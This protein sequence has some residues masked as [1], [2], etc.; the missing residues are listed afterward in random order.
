MQLLS[1]LHLRVAFCVWLCV[2]STS[3]DRPRRVRPLPNP[4]QPKNASAS[5]HYIRRRESWNLRSVSPPKV[6]TT[7]SAA[8]SNGSATAGGFGDSGGDAS[9]TT[10]GVSPPR[11]RET[12]SHRAIVSDGTNSTP[13]ASPRQTMLSDLFQKSRIAAGAQMRT[14]TPARRRSQTRTRT[15]GDGY[16]A[17]WRVCVCV[18]FVL[19]HD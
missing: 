18:C 1:L 8:A 5:V 2:C 3:G 14:T 6:V 16:A 13:L 4:V 12:L 17:I 19:E 11:A 15:S 10:V 9:V 7:P